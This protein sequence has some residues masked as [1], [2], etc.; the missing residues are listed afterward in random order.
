MST[1]PAAARDRCPRCG[2]DFHCGVRDPGPCACTTV[3]LDPTLQLRLRERFRGCLCL[4]CLQALAGVG[5]LD[6]AAVAATPGPGAP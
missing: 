2:G 3:A 4:R 1:V 5:A 6:V